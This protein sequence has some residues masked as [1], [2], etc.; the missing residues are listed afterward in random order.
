M[1]QDSALSAATRAAVIGDLPGAFAYAIIPY[2]GEITVE[3]FPDAESMRRALAA[4]YIRGS[5]WQYPLSWASVLIIEPERPG[6]YYM[7]LELTDADFEV[8]P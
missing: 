2:D 5:K 7:V 8:T 3:S 6:R 1:A 4:L